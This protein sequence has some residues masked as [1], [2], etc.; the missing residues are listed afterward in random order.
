MP[1]YE[2]ELPEPEGEDTHSI[3]VFAEDISQAISKYVFAIEKDSGVE[4]SAEEPIFIRKV[5]ENGDLI[6]SDDFVECEDV[7]EEIAEAEAGA[8]CIAWT[9]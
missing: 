2:I 9:D 3:Y 6:L 8:S 1:L 5:C 7:D 4:G